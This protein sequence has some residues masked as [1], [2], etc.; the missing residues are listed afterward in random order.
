MSL[1]P[2][3]VAMCVASGVLGF[4]FC[5]GLATVFARAVRSDPPLLVL[6]LAGALV[7]APVAVGLVG[8]DPGS[9]TVVVAGIG[10]VFGA[11]CELIAFTAFP[12]AS[13]GK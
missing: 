3:S 11:F 1:F 13:D 8:P 7:G 6:Y 5:A 10:G 9:A 4:L 12:R 2:D